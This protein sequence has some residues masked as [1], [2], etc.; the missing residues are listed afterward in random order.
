LPRAHLNKDKAITNR[1]RL[2]G[3]FAKFNFYRY[4]ALRLIPLRAPQKELNAAVGVRVRVHSK[5]QI[6]QFPT[7]SGRQLAMKEELSTL[8]K[9]RW[10]DKIAGV[11]PVH[12]EEPTTCEIWL[13]LNEFL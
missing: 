13:L 3:I 5:V 12:D 6:G 1:R 2:G 11:T 7:E 9:N 8:L 10:S 4:L